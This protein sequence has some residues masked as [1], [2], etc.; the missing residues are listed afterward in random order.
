[1]VFK[2]RKQALQAQKKS[3][4]GKR[5]PELKKAW[6]EA[7]QIKEAYLSGESGLK[8]AKRYNISYRS[9]Y[10]IINSYKSD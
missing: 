6:V 8:I 9:C 7:E 2:N 5:T 10:R 1:M 4:D 3:I